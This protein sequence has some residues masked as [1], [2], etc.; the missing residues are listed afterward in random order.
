MGEIYDVSVYDG[1]DKRRLCVDVGSYSKSNLRQL[2]MKLYGICQQKTGRLVR[3]C[4]LD[5]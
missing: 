4:N 5:M 3:V 1:S 2:Q